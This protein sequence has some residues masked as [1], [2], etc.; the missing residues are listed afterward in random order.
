MPLRVRRRAGALLGGRW[1]TR[2]P[3]N[4]CARVT[5]ARRIRCLP[6]LSAMLRQVLRYPHPRRRCAQPVRL[7]R[8]PG[9][10]ASRQ[11]R[12]S[13]K[14]PN[15]LSSKYC[16]FGPHESHRLAIQ[17]SE[18]VGRLRGFFPGPEGPRTDWCEL[19]P[20]FRACGAVQSKLHVNSTFPKPDRP[21][22]TTGLPLTL[23][24][25]GR[26]SSVQ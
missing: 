21:W 14:S 25:S 3:H 22:T 24:I 18:A 23:T 19:V 6:A 17:K 15:A 1:R 26:Y 4:R 13:A 20:N 7:S 5:R 12:P 11:A 9:Q 16:R 10:H 8:P 2:R